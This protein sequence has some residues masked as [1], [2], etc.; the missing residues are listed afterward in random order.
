MEVGGPRREGGETRLLCSV[1]AH[2]RAQ[3]VHPSYP[4]QVVWRR[5]GQPL[6]SGRRTPAK[7]S[8]E[9][10]RAEHLLRLTATE[11]GNYSCVATNRLGEDTAAI[12]VTGDQTLL[13]LTA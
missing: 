13:V 8:T 10:H 3:V 6:S 7:D 4:P 11:Y 9:P 12:M 5:D 2:P 1:H